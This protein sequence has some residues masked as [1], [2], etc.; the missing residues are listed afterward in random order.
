MQT[1]TFYELK[2]EKKKGLF[3]T[4]SFCLKYFRNERAHR[5]LCL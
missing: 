5:P 4:Q 1:D 2:G 3:K